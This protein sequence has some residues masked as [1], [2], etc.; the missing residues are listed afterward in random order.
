MQRMETADSLQ[1]TVKLEDIFTV[2]GILN[3]I[4]IINIVIIII[5][6]LSSLA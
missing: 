3:N 6:S 5:I 2:T 1:E 4:V